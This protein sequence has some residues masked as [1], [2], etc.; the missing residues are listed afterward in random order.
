MEAALVVTDKPSLAP[1]GVSDLGSALL[2][3]LEPLLA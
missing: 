2:W 3:M 1:P